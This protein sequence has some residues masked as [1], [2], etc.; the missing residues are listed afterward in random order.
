[1]EVPADILDSLPRQTF[2]DGEKIINQGEASKGLLYFLVSGTII[3]QKDGHTVTEEKRPGA[4]FGETS[5]LLDMPHSADVLA[6]GETT[7]AIVE[8]PDIFL[9]QHPAVM[10]FIGQILSRRLHAMTDFF[11]NVKQKYGSQLDLGAI[12]DMIY[13]LPED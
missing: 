4:T 2:A 3:V 13:T 7:L 6:K 11:T 8:D 1:M 9:H 5:I 10:L 12:E